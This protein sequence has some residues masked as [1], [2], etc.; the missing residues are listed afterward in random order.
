MQT[1]K[2]TTS[3]NIDIEYEVAGVG[4]REGESDHDGRGELL[5]RH[6]PSGVAKEEFAIALADVADV[7]PSDVVVLTVDYER[8]LE[9]KDD[10]DGGKAEGE[11]ER[12]CR[13]HG[14]SMSGNS[15]VRSPIAG[16]YPQRW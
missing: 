4:E 15:P 3:Q 16:K 8:A 12:A 10:A 11:G 9:G 1:V 2:I 7:H 14:G 6:S 5:Q 13:A